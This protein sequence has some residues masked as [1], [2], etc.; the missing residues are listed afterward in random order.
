MTVSA[1]HRAAPE[2]PG[3]A[4]GSVV[5]LLD[6]LFQVSV[7]LLQGFAGTLAGAPVMSRVMPRTWVDLPVGIRQHRGHTSVAT[8]RP[9][10][11]PLFSSPRCTGVFDPG[12]PLH[13]FVDQSPGRF[14]SNPAAENTSDVIWLLTGRWGGFS[15]ASPSTVTLLG[16]QPEEMLHK[17]LMIFCCRIRSNLPGD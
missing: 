11:P 15:Y 10:F 6:P 2:P 12:L 7:E 5:A 16:Y 14:R 13:E 1:W 4:S 3:C 8:A 9:V 17:E